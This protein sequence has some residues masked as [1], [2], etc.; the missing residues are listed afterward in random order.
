M[1]RDW[2]E[3][4]YNIRMITS[5]NIFS[6]QKQKCVMFN[7]KCETFFPLVCR[8]QISMTVEFATVLRSQGTF[9][10]FEFHIL[11]RT[12]QH[13][14]LLTLSIVVII[15]LVMFDVTMR[16]KCGA[17]SH[18]IYIDHNNR[19]IYTETHIVWNFFNS[20]RR[21]LNT[22]QVMILKSSLQR[23]KRKQSLRCEIFMI[24][25]LIFIIIIT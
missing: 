12:C 3:G 6:F 15:N 24:P 23:R 10:H 14:C 16:C 9:R 17:V 7:V 5:G 21:F 1:K 4:Q 20:A 2:Y 25:I 18:N 19:W 11:T 8:H 13:N 22:N